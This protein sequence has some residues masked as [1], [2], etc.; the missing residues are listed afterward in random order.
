VLQ[1]E[2]VCAGQQ[3]QPLT[4]GQNR[5]HPLYSTLMDLFKSL[6]QFPSL[7]PSQHALLP[8]LRESLSTAYLC[9][10]ECEA[11]VHN[12]VVQT[13]LKVWTSLDSSASSLKPLVASSSSSELSP[14]HK[15][16]LSSSSSSSSTTLKPDTRATSML[17]ADDETPGD[18]LARFL[19]KHGVEP[20]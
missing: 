8:R 5:S 15:S 14:D 2:E 6:E 7:T 17:D 1:V 18:V 13:Q 10:D 4:I 9:T 20:D 3:K 12:G 11:K 16:E 19:R